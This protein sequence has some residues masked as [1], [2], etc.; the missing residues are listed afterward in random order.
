MATS[1]QD[2]PQRRRFITRHDVEDAASSGQPIRLRGRDVVTSEAAQRATDLG[3]QI[4]RDQATGTTF[5]SSVNTTPG[6]SV[7]TS[8]SASP[9]A[10]AA[11]VTSDADLRRAVRAAVVAEL[12][13]EA[14]GLDLAIDKVLKNRSR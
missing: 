13:A 7:K 11:P 5:G 3:V 4:E 2:R 1:E 10:A 14:P 12:G 6:S 9:P 8:P